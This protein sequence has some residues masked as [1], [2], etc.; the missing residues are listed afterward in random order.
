MMINIVVKCTHSFQIAK[1]RNAEQL[2]WGKH[3]TFVLK[4]YYITIKYYCYSLYLLLR[5]FSVL[6]GIMVTLKA[7]N[8][9]TNWKKK[10]TMFVD[11]GWPIQIEW[12]LNQS[13]SCLAL[14][15]SEESGEHRPLARTGS[16]T[17][18]EQK[19]ITTF[20]MGYNICRSQTL[21]RMWWKL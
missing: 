5:N 8:I 21:L 16:L 13:V 3:N 19:Y 12:L 6:H 2:L 11:F 14:N 7:I 10:R 4:R 1:I 15:V 20:N 18:R 9:K 17:S